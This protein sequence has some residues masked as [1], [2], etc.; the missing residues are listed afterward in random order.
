[1]N[2]FIF[3]QTAGFRNAYRAGCAAAVALLACGG[4]EFDGRVFR[5]GNVAF[6]L[7]NVPSDWRT[8]EISDTAVAFR[9]DANAAT[10]AIN[11]RCGQDA[12][13][14]PLKALTQ[15][16]FLQFTQR[17][18]F[19]Q[20]LLALDGRE[21]MRTRMVAKLDGVS[22]FFDVVVLKKNGCV[23]DFLQI[24]NSSQDPNQ[25][26]RFVRGFSSLS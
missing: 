23:F 5:D 16:L 14:V 12:E 15:H 4:P 7:H 25:F 17:E 18:Q 8:L 9:D 20:A 3:F 22:K 6:R 19:T 11:G 13:D 26:L 24:A 10:V 1:M 2:R 21:A